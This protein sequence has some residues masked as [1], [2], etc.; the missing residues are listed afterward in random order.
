MIVLYLRVIGRKWKRNI[1]IKVFQVW[2]I[3]KKSPES[4]RWIPEKAWYTRR[5]IWKGNLAVHV[6]RRITVS[7]I[8]R[9]RSGFLRV[10]Q[11]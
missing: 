6:V 7:N 4:P 5:S 2:W 9:R 10:H 1:F 8:Q 3:R 11:V